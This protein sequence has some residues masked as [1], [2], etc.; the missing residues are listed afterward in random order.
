MTDTSGALPGLEPRDR[1][2]A[3]AIRHASAAG[4]RHHPDCTNKGRRN[5]HTGYSP[6]TWKDLSTSGCPWCEYIKKE[7]GTG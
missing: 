4:L 7:T 2:W 5:S 6:R 1:R 3:A